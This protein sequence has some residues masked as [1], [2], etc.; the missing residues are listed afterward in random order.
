MVPHHIAVLGGGLTGLSSAFHLSRRFPSSIVTLIDKQKRLG[1]WASNTERVKLPNG[2]SVVLEGGPR[3]LRPNSYAVLELIHLLGLSDALITTPKSSPAAKNRYLHVP[4]TPGIYRIPGL[5]LSYLWSELRFFIT[6]GVTFDLVRGWNR[7]EGITDES[8]E[9][10]ILRRGHPDFARVLGSALVHGIYAADA[11]KLSVRAALPMLWEYE[12]RG[13]GRVLRGIMRQ[14]KEAARLKL[15]ETLAGYELGDLWRRMDGVSVYSFRDGMGTLA[16]TLGKALKARPNVR[17]LQ[18]TEVASLVPPNPENE[19][20][21]ITT[22]STNALYPSH[23]VSALPLPALHKLAP[24]LPHLLANPTSSVTAVNLVFPVA[25]GK[26]FPRGFGYLVSRPAYDYLADDAGILGVTFDSESL[27]AQDDIPNGQQYT[28]VT[29]MLGGPH[30]AYQKVDT[31]LPVIL[32]HL[33]YHLNRAKP[34]PDP[35]VTRFWSHQNCIPTPTV[36]HLDRMEELR[37]ALVAEDGPWGGRLEVVGA[38]VKGVSMADCVEKVLDPNLHLAMAALYEPIPVAMSRNE[39]DSTASTASTV[40][41][42]S[43]LNTP[44]DEHTLNFDLI[45]GA[46]LAATPPKALAYAADLGYRKS[47]SQRVSVSRQFAKAIEAANK[48]NVGIIRVATP[49][50]IVEPHFMDAFDSPPVPNSSPELDSGSMTMPQVESTTRPATPPLQM[51][52]ESIARTPPSRIQRLPRSDIFSPAPPLIPLGLHEEVEFTPRAHS[53]LR[54]RRGPLLPTSESLLSELETPI[55]EPPAVVTVVVPEPTVNTDTQGL[56]VLELFRVPLT[57]LQ[58]VTFPFYTALVGATILLAPDQLSAIAFP[59]TITTNDSG[60]LFKIMLSLIF[61]FSAPAGP[62][63]L[64]RVFA[65]WVTV[66]HLHVAIFLAVLGGVAYLNL[67]AGAL[68]VAACV[69]RMVQPAAWGGFAIPGVDDDDEEL[70][71]DVRQTLWRAVVAAPGSGL[72]EGEEMKEVEGRYY[73]VRKV[74]TLG[75]I[76]KAGG[77]DSEYCHSDESGDEE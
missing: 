26:L 31:A 52:Q 57:L 56:L 20:F 70:G 5:S 10:F 28:K 30:N 18:G 36:G 32:A 12:E 9:D 55:T 46:L 1:G 60:S 15:E 45:D 14:D 8:F 16:E 38:G 75:D 37:A 73:V 29:V 47:A 58:F 43:V 3:T 65:H 23:V 17:I 53:T 7:P 71:A 42:D 62:N 51:T 49:P 11:R 61:P 63:E 44:A 21:E 2:G 64:I 25:P 6:P 33:R 22:K 68:L 72:R 4:G 41:D 54:H 50:H 59:A 66:A 13:N 67:V 24:T 27:A 77:L 74:E 76:L 69:A 35:V 19:N 34:I 48:S 40:S 39:N